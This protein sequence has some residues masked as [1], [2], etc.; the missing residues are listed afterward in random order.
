MNIFMRNMTLT[1]YIRRCSDIILDT[2]ALRSSNSTEL[3]Q[4]ISVIVKKHLE[5]WEVWCLCCSWW[6]SALRRWLQAVRALFYFHFWIKTKSIY[7][8]LF[9]EV[10]FVAFGDLKCCDMIKLK[11]FV[12]FLHILAVISIDVAQSK[13]CVEFSDVKIPVKL[14]TSYYWTRSHCPRRAIVWVHHIIS[15]SHCKIQFVWD[16]PLKD[17]NRI[18]ASFPSGFRQKQGESSV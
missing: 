13:C 8:W 12:L 1:M 14:V 9:M 3:L 18:F 2:T 10:V 4:I 11:T 16:T 7:F 6:S 15:F 5:E 17:L